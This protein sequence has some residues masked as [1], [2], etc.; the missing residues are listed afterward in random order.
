MDHSILLKKLF[1]YGFHDASFDWCQSYL[2]G[3][4]QQVF[5]NGKLSD[6]LDE[7]PFGVPR[8]SVLGPLFF[9]LYINDINSIIISSYVHLY[10]DDTIII[11]AHNNPVSLIKNME[12]ELDHV[13]DW[14]L[15]N[16]L[17]P[18]KKKCETIFFTNS[19]NAKACDDLKVKFRGVDLQ[20]KQ[21]VKYLG[22]HFDCK[23]SWCKQINDIKRKIN[24]KLAKIRPLAKFLDTEDVFMLIR[25]FI[26][27][28]IHYCSPTWSSAAK[29]LI[30]KIQS[31]C[32]KTQLFSHD[33]PK[34]DVRQRLHFDLSIL[35]FK[36]IH[37][38]SP[39]YL[40]NKLSLTSHNH[41]HYTRQA[42]AMNLFHTFTPNKLSTQSIKFLAPQ[43][44]NSLPCELKNEQNFRMFKNKCR[45]YFLHNF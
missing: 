41:N 35:I 29:H 17:T 6:I 13:H 8:G 39:S 7:Q 31:S 42:S 20:T 19:R 1:C 11:Q 15:V 12:T 18:N 3:R 45:K 24:Y 21:S 38:L 10:A 34:I 14:F 27:P 40:C 2:Q 28:Y 5:A 33:I 23:L 30:E 37:N 22:I 26:F 9:L 43:F 4:K 32:D 16:K 44:W 25:S 36:S